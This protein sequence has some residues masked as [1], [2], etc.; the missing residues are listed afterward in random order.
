MG[1]PPG[2]K[3]RW[4][5]TGGEAPSRRFTPG[6]IGSP[7][8]LQ[9]CGRGGRRDRQASGVAAAAG[10][11][12]GAS[13]R[14]QRPEGLPRPGVRARR[15]QDLPQPMLLGRRAPWLGSSPSRRR[16]RRGP[17]ARSGRRIGGRN[18][19]ERS[20]HGPSRFGTWHSLS[21]IQSGWRRPGPQGGGEAYFRIR[22]KGLPIGRPCCIYT[23]R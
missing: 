19:G 5:G 22:K 16:G 10:G 3:Q 13:V 12:A 14:L 20:F 21:W 18:F 2:Y 4:Q 6:H 8:G 11:T 1:R 15:P 9:R 7:S 23:G 17:I